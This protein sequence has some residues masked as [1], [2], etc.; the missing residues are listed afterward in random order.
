MTADGD[1]S[2]RND[3]RAFDLYRAN[4]AA[5]RS[6]YK[7]DLLGIIHRDGA[8]MLFF[9][10]QLGY[11]AGQPQWQGTLELGWVQG[12]GPFS[13]RAGPGG[14]SLSARI[15]GSCSFLCSGG[16]AGASIRVTDTRS[17]FEFAP[18]LPNDITAVNV[19]GG[20]VPRT[21]ALQLSEGAAFHGLSTADP[22]LLDETFRF[23]WSQLPE[24]K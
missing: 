20:P 24:A 21:I 9:A 18:S 10:H 5:L 15:S 17:G 4:L 1:F 14:A 2:E 12:F 13:Y 3:P 11:L 19:P 22:Q 6:G 16:D 8:G 7:T 23:D